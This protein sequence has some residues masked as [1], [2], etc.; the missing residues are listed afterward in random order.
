MAATSKSTVH[1]VQ[2][3]V[4]GLVGCG[5]RSKEGLELT[6]ESNGLV[7]AQ[8]REAV[9]HTGVGHAKSHACCEL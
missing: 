7:T 6:A 2:N 1:E 4:D 9:A 5:T 3:Y 8:R